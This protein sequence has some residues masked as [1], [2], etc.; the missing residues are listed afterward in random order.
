MIL[1]AL[2]SICVLSSEP[3]SWPQFR[4]AAFG[5]ADDAKYPD[6]LDPDKNL[7]VDLGI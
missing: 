6:S 5:V 4:G 2:A 7:G 3:L 1:Y